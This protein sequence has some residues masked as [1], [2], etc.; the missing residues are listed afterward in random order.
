VVMAASG[1]GSTT[2]LRPQPATY[3]SRPTLTDPN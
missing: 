3:Q 1:G 2:S